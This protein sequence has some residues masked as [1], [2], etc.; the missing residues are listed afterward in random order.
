ML[1]DRARLAI[2]L[3]LAALLLSLVSGQ[4]LAETEPPS[5]TAASLFV[6]DANSGETLY[7]K[8][9]GKPAPLH[10][11]TKL[12]TAYVLVGAMGDKLS[13]AVT[14][15]PKHLTT[16]A[17]AGLRKGDVWTLSDLLAGMLLVSGNDAA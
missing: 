11:L 14:I 15:M 4:A 7:H 13:E 12:M 3:G 2:R 8:G 9:G 16:G 1:A 6:L 5:V 17:T 10:S